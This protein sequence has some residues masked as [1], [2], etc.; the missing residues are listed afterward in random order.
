MKVGRSVFFFRF[1]RFFIIC[2][3]KREKNQAMISP[4]NSPR[5]APRSAIP[6]DR[7]AHRRAG[8]LHAAIPVRDRRDATAK[9]RM[10]MMRPAIGGGE[11]SA[12]TSSPPASS[13][14][15]PTST[16]SSA[17]AALVDALLASVAGASAD[18]GSSMS[19][20]ERA[21]ADSLFDRLSRAAKDER[22]KGRELLLPPLLLPLFRRSTP[23]SCSA[24]STSLTSPRA[25]SRRV[26][27]REG[28]SG[29]GSGKQF[30]RRLQFASRSSTKK[31][32]KMLKKKKKQTER[33]RRSRC[34]SRTRS[35]SASRGS[36]RARWACEGR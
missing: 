23:P 9:A 6:I 36:W 20:A 13:S 8:C 7:P 22:K 29:L 35:R 10:P 32:R 31:K 33:R 5:I 18:R 14:S 25:G 15:T 12:E 24:T 17:P 34:S 3:G 21:A 11:Q 19:P 30:S 26:S 28:I 4:R 1:F 2:L 16:S 27:R